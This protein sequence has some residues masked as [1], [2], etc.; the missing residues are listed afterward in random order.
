LVVN[1][2]PDRENPPRLGEKEPIRGF[3]LRPGRDSGA[4][5]P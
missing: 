3:A 4:A 2:R 1:S 5:G